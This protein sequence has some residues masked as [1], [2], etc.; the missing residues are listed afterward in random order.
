MKS[1]IKVSII[2]LFLTSCTAR[3]CQSWNRSMQFS[4]RSYEVEMYSGDSCVFRDKFHGIL[5]QEDHSDGFYYFKGDT[6]VE[7]GGNYVIKSLK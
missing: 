5:N 3:G 6:L 4:D 7:I 2:L 1:I